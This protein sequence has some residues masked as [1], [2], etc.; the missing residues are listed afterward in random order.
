MRKN[1][2]EVLKIAKKFFKESLNHEN[3]AVKN[4]RLIK[5]NYKGAALNVLK[6]YLD[7]VRRHQNAQTLT[8]ESADR[9]N[10]RLTVEFLKSF[11]RKAD[12][13]L[14]LKT[15]TN[16]M[17]ISGVRVTLGDNQWDFSLRNRLD[18]LK[19]ALSG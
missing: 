15:K 8:I 17:L 14:D 10:H 19:E 7:L 12:K 9:I 5:K 4:I 18:Q 2:K 13:K 16:P 1:K 3:L 11:E 6:A